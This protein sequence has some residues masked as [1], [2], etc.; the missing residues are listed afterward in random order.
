[1]FRYSEPED[2]DSCVVDS[3]RDK[4]SPAYIHSQVKHLHPICG[5]RW[6][7]KL[8]A[9]LPWNT[10]Y[11]HNYQNMVLCCALIEDHGELVDY[12]LSGHFIHKRLRFNQQRSLKYT[13]H[14]AV[15]KNNAKVV[16]R[17]MT[18]YCADMPQ[19]QITTAIA[20]AI[21]QDKKEIFNI[22]SSHGEGL[23]LLHMACQ[24]EAVQCAEYLLQTNT[25]DTN[26]SIRM[27]T[28]Y[29]RQGDHKL[30][31]TKDCSWHDR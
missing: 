7:H 16:N 25:S 5:T 8:C 23:P 29:I 14:I 18:K 22:L 10:A 2:L 17:L 26:A 1:M 13:L 31:T 27:G 24:Y 12:I 28:S 21:K 9:T 30:G 11:M 3:I 6:W 15:E 4:A 19:W 20:L